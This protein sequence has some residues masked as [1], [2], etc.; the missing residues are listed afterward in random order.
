MGLNL[1]FVNFQVLYTNQKTKKA[2]TW[3]DGSLKFS[4]GGTKVGI[5]QN[6]DWWNGKWARIFI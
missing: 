5:A 4:G 6:D 2:K 3:H 1:I